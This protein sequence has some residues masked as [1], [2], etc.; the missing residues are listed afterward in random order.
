MHRADARHPD[1]A[2]AGARILLYL[3]LGFFSVSLV[4]GERPKQHL[5]EL[6]QATPGDRTAGGG[7][8]PELQPLD[9]VS[10]HM[11]RL[12]DRYSD[13]GRVEAARMPSS[14]QRSSQPRR[15]QPLREGNTV[16]SFRAGAAGD[17]KSKGLHIFNL[18][19][20][21]KSENILS[22]T[23]YFY[24]GELVNISWNCPASPRCS[25][26]A[27]RKHI[28]IE[29]SA[30]CLQANLNQSQLLGHLS[31]DIAKPHRDTMSWLSKDITQL[32]KK[33]KENEDLLIGFNMTPKAQQPPKRMVPFP[34]PYILVY[35][36]DVAIS[37]PESVVSSLQ[38]HWNF[39]TGAVPKLDS[40][41]RAALSM[42]RRKKRSTGILLPLQNNELPGA[43]YQY[44]E[45]GVWEERKPY[46]TL[47]TQ[48]PEKN[49]N[50][51]KQRKGP[52]QK[53][54]TLQF[55]EQTLKKAR[56]KQWVEPRNCAKRYLKVDFADIGW[57]EWIISPK[58]FDAYYC[59]GACQFP[60]PKSLK[61]SNHATIQSIVRAVG[62]VP[63]IPEPCCVPE[64]MSSLSILFFDE[65]KN[66]VLK[67]YPNMT[68]ESCACR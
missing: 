18:T 65:N 19:S 42:E 10:E 51:K 43:E 21:T 56:R 44:Q 38:G 9:K 67:V 58:S 4:Q 27:Q 5:P 59:S 25:H 30:W 63:G 1:L 28:Q 41:I 61:P 16:R 40:H 17:L 49:K 34:E 37:E 23:L 12:Y 7:P 26:H 60:M 50:K 11:L 31:V 3:W 53:S 33:A 66:V 62:V 54:Q 39:P 8:G 68:V 46:K 32:L 15:P 2:M 57:S 13:S 64:K 6:H 14:R 24:I 52:H 22:A 45:E 36:N 48:P 55:D 20:L 35:A 47:Q 29:L